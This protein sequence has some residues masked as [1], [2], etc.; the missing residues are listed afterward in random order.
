M[1]IPAFAPM[2][3][4]TTSSIGTR[5]SVGPLMG[6]VFLLLLA[7]CA[8][9]LMRESS[10]V[11]EEL[12]RWRLQLPPQLSQFQLQFL[13]KDDAH[14]SPYISS[15]SELE[16][17][18]EQLEE[19]LKFKRQQDSL[20]HEAFYS[21]TEQ[22]L[23]CRERKTMSKC[24]DVESIDPTNQTCVWCSSLSICVAGNQIH[25]PESYRTHCPYWCGNGSSLRPSSLYLRSSFFGCCCCWP[26]M[27]NTIFFSLR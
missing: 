2:T 12:E 10:L 27:A 25:G 23:R 20:E 8:L 26:M 21:S 13:R 17:K 14:S 6:F 3:T 16:A 5:R 1:T 24:L 4:N 11:Q 9:M 15:V 19:A 18:I 7:S 22:D